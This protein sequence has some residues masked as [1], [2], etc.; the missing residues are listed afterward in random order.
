[1]NLYDSLSMLRHWHDHKVK[2]QPDFDDALG[3]VLQYMQQKVTTDD[4]PGLDEAV[5]TVLQYMEQ[6]VIIR[7]MT[8]F[9]QQKG[10]TSTPS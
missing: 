8:K 7:D 4:I 6:K 10:W 3:K 9:S 1:M 2:P 5:E